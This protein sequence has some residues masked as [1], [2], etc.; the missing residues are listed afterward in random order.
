[1]RARIPRKET[2]RK[3]VMQRVKIPKR[4]TLHGVTY[5]VIIDPELSV[6]TDNVGEA[7]YRKSEIHV[8]GISPGYQMNPQRQEQV[9]LHEL[10]HHILH[11]M[12]HKLRDDEGFVDLFSAILHQALI[13]SEYEENNGQA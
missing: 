5:Q 12:H 9:Y 1:M 10:T 8:Q 13:T 3:L 4:V 11:E 2:G 6:K 7:S